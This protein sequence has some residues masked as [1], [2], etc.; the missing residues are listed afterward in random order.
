MESLHCWMIKAKGNGCRYKESEWFLVFLCPFV[1]NL[2]LMTRPHLIFICWMHV[3]A[4]VRIWYPDNAHL[5]WFNFASSFIFAA[6]G[7]RYCIYSILYRL[8]EH[9]SVIIEKILL[10]VFAFLN[11]ESLAGLRGKL[12][13]RNIKSFAI[14]RYIWYWPYSVGFPK[15]WNWSFTFDAFVNKYAKFTNHF[16]YIYCTGTSYNTIISFEVALFGVRIMSFP[17]WLY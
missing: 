10:R 4:F 17:T 5:E 14:L 9:I 1:K 7:F 3:N 8:W 11:R 2:S 15:S 13:H 6:S 12:K 16:V